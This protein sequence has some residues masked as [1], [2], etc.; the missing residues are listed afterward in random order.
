VDLAASLHCGTR[1]EYPIIRRALAGIPKRQERP[2]VDVERDHS[3]VAVAV[4]QLCYRIH[5]Y[6]GLH[7]H[8]FVQHAFRHQQD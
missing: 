7:S 1:G 4:D 2:E 3:A 6:W 5:I 8:Q